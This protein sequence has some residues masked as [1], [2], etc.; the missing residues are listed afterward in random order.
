MVLVHCHVLVTDC[1]SLGTPNPSAVPAT[2][3][4]MKQATVPAIIA[5]KAPS[6]IS[7]FF[8]GA[9]LARKK[10]K[11]YVKQKLYIKRRRICHLLPPQEEFPAPQFELRETQRKNGAFFSGLFEGQVPVLALSTKRVAYM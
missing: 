5:L 1:D 3:A 9:M 4:V 11:V 8:V 2:Q 6:A 10:N 7:F